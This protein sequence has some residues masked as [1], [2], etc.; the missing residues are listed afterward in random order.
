[1]QS[2]HNKGLI[3][4]TMITL[5]GLHCKNERIHTGNVKVTTSQS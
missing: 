5:T 4:L 2:D 1:M 3:P